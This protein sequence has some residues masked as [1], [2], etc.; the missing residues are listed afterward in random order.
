MEENTAR[1]DEFLLDEQVVNTSTRKCTN[2]GANMVYDPQSNSLICPHC[3]SKEAIEFTGKACELELSSAFS[4]DVGD[5]AEKS[6]TFVCGNCGAKIVLSQSETAKNCPFCGTAHVAESQA[7]EGL[8][9]NAVLPFAFGIDKALEFCKKWARKTKLSPKKFKKNLSVE[10]LR[11]VYVPCFTFDSRTTSI[12]NGKIGKRYTRV[13]GSGKDRRTETYVVWRNISG[14][15]FSNF[16][17][18]LVTAGSKFDQKRLNKISPYL[19][20]ESVEYTEEYLLGYMAYHYDMEVTDCWDSAK[21]QID[22]MLRNQ[23]LS[24]YSYDEV[25]Y[26]NVSTTHEQVTYKYVML[27][28]YLGRF[29][30]NKKHYEFQVNGCTGKVAGKTPKSPA[31]ITSLV[32]GILAAVG[33]IGYL[34]YKFMVQ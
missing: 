33:V 14:R 6:V 5:K 32:M 4:K 23:I 29:D 13:V 21:S 2:C 1:V 31:K 18:V 25:A 34:I 16:D 20:N 22:D 11:G 8:K 27:P 26:L 10:N 17:D 28:V 7:L 24:Q 19:T 30:F 12:Y 3:D 9:P 15:Y